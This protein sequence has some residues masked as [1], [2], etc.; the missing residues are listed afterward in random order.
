MM[1]FG[2]NSEL[3]EEGKKDETL[4]INSVTHTESTNIYI[5]NIRIVDIY[6]IISNQQIWILLKKF[7]Y[8]Q[9]HEF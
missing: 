4:E 2:N 5:L 7:L 9:G 1:N 6:E 3:S 8:R